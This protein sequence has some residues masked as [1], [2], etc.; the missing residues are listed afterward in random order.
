MLGEKKV[1]EEGKTEEEILIP[2]SGQ[3]FTKKTLKKGRKTWPNLVK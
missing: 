3:L 2:L 1:W